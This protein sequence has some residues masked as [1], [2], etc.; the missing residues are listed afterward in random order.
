M[1]TQ[2]VDERHDSDAIH[3]LISVRDRT[4]AKSTEKRRFEKRVEQETLHVAQQHKGKALEAEAVLNQHLDSLHEQV[5]VVLEMFEDAEDVDM[6]HEAKRIFA[7]IRNKRRNV[8]A[9]MADGNASQAE[10]KGIRAAVRIFDDLED[11]FID[12]FELLA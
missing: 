1:D 7:R 11:Q 6:E 12:R 4:R 10:R 8:T 2:D 5:L 9:R 3:F